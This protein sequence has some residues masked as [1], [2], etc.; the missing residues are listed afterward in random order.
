LNENRTSGRDIYVVRLKTELPKPEDLTEE[1]AANY[2]PKYESIDVPV[3]D[4]GDGT[5]HVKYA[6][7]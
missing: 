1:E 7:D 6:F 4:N 3:V 5:H 2:R